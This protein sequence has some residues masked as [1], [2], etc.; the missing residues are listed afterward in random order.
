MV[1]F[2]LF[3]ACGLMYFFRDNVG[4]LLSCLGI[5]CCLTI[6]RMSVVISYWLNLLDNAVSI[7]Y[8]DKEENK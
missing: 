6:L 8:Q 2:D 7:E 5:A 3:V 4:A 1:I